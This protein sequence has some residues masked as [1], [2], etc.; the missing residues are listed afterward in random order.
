MGDEMLCWP[1]A[2]VELADEPRDAGDQLQQLLARGDEL[3]AQRNR[4]VRAVLLRYDWR[5]RIG[6]LCGHFGLPVP[7]ALHDDL[8]R[9]HALAERFA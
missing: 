3:Q 8:Q 1:G 7:P 4:N 5:H 9:A 6:E 2:T